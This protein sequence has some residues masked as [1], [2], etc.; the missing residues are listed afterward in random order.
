M[1]VKRLNNLRR[2]KMRFLTSKTGN[3]FG[4]IDLKVYDLKENKEFHFYE[5]E[6]SHSIAWKQAKAKRFSSEDADQIR[7]AFDKLHIIDCKPLDYKLLK[8]ELKNEID[9]KFI[10]LAKKI[11][12]I[13]CY[14]TQLKILR[15]LDA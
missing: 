15:H 11:R 9:E 3:N 2:C 6:G 14:G 7:E 12:K 4:D 10:K 13:D 1:N 5:S 8:Q